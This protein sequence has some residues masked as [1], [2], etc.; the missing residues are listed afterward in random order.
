MAPRTATQKPSASQK[1][2]EQKGPARPAGA[3]E[4]QPGQISTEACHVIAHKHGWTLATYKNE[5][6]STGAVMT[7][8]EAAIH[9]D[10][11]NRIIIATG[12]PSQGGCG[13]Q[14]VINAS[15]RLETSKTQTIHITGTPNEERVKGKDGKEEIKKRPAYS[16]MVE[17]DI[18]IEAA[19]EVSIGGSNVTLVAKNV[20]TLKGTEIN[21][22]AGNGGGKVNVHA[23]DI[24][25]NIAFEKTVNTGGSH[26]EVKGE[27]TVNQ[28]SNPGAVAAINTIGGINLLVRGDYNIST[29][30]Q[31]QVNAMG[32]ILFSSTKGGLA[33][34]ASGKHFSW[35]G[36]VKEENIL[37][38]S[39]STSSTKP[40]TTY[41]LK[42]GPNK[43]GLQLDSTGSINMQA[44]GADATITAP[45]GINLFAGKKLTAV[46]AAIFL[47]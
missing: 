1:K 27:F 11:N 29:L 20:L 7:N 41:S 19:G 45:I 16:L 9:F 5:D 6:G 38:K 23:A 10:A 8:G 36:G 33:T 15:E 14:V 21:L 47:N 13:G 32:N 4:L 46:A 18:A 37:G 34:I 40:L 22:E 25:K 3:D 43:T 42:L 31:Y 28:K 44:I 26:S 39:I 2:L 30:G 12:D 24:N 35:I 17:G